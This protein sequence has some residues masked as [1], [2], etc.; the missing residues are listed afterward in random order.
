MSEL[1]HEEV[2][3]ILEAIEKSEFDF[4][5]LRLGEL[6]L[7]VS[8]TSSAIGAP[9]RLPSEAPTRSLPAAGAVGRGDPAPTGSAVPGSTASAA[10]DVPA[11]G[12]S[13]ES[14]RSKVAA[15]AAPADGLVEVKAPMVGTF[16]AQP[17]P[18]APPYVDVGSQ[19]EED[20]TLGL[21]EVMKV[22]NAISA[23]VRGVVE[24][25]LVRNAEFVEFG[26]PL[27]LIRP[28]GGEAAG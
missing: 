20:T 19:V 14:E 5:E 12:G 8:K 3:Q 7:T 13:D 24:R 1:S 22:F 11:E 16:Y 27:F 10:P 18:G 9:G 26:Q 23:G 6:K 21:V 2:L 4:F 28:G 15:V 17:E 25:I